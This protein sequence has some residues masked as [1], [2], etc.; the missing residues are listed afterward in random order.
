MSIS[1][2]GPA[3]DHQLTL[4][5]VAAAAP[6]FVTG[7]LVGSLADKFG[8]EWIIAPGLLFSAPWLALMILK[9]SL[10]GFI[11]YFALSQTLLGCS[12]APVGLEVAMAAREVVSGVDP[13]WHCSA[14]GSFRRE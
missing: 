11:V 2:N 4:I 8:A 14:E 13:S 10:A 6:T 5:S 12:M 1:S 7:P 3:F 9:S